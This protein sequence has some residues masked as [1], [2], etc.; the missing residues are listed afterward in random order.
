[1]ERREREALET[2][3]KLKR[4]ESLRRLREKHLEERKVQEAKQREEE[5]RKA[6]ELQA[7][8]KADQDLLKQERLHI[9]NQPVVENKASQKQRPKPEEPRQWLPDKLK[10]EFWMDKYQEYREK[11]D[12]K[13][14]LKAEEQFARWASFK[15]SRAGHVS[16]QNDSYT[17][18]FAGNRN[19]ILKSLF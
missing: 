15:V 13:R 2:K 18:G 9:N 19:S 17:G 3:E 16:R 5:E 11:K 4:E 6:H 7:L 1:M 8:K 12:K 14:K 10:V